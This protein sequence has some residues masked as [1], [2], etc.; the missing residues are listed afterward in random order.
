MILK[1]RDF[2]TLLGGAAAWPIAAKAQQT[3]I[4]VIGV[5][6]GTSEAE[7]AGGIAAFRAGL[8]ELGFIEGRNVAIQYRWAEGH[9][10]RL[11]AM[12]ADLV[13]RKVAVIWAGGSLQGVRAA[14]AA[15]RTIPIVF[16]T[17]TDPVASGVVASLNRPG[18]NVT[19]VT[20]LGSELEP[21]RIEMLHEMIPS[22]A[23]FA[24]LVN[25]NNTI[26]MKERIEGAQTAAQRLG[27]E[28]VILKAGT[29]ADIEAAFKAATE[30]RAS[31]LLADDAYFDSRR[32]QFAALGLRDRLP[33]ALGSRDSVAAGVLMSYGASSV[34]SFRQ[35]G[36]YVGRILKGEKPADL[37][38]VQPTKFELVI[39]LKTAKAIGLDISPLLLARADEVIEQ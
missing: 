24:V 3:A 20:S 15:T 30:Q 23:R 34:D 10:D 6:N 25:P 32:D 21:K 22:A 28:L 11:P 13:A 27:L 33:V 5:L 37:P 31:A 2:I 36:V 8:G 12:A 4:P 26:T 35:A 1:R 7:L 16:T 18:G 9:T 39:N 38:V 19:G 17:A 14:M 29:A